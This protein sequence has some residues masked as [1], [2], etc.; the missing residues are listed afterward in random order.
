M[1]DDTVKVTAKITVKVT[2]DPDGY[3]D[4]FEPL[5]KN[6]AKSHSIL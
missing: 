3:C 2:V 5:L 4:F 6:H 1:A